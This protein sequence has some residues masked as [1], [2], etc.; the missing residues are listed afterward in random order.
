ML[1]EHARHAVPDWSWAAECVALR[2][3]ML[4]SGLLSTACIGCVGRQLGSCFEKFLSS[5]KHEKHEAAQNE[6][7]AG[8]VAG[9]ASGGS[10]L[11]TAVATV[12]PAAAGTAAYKAPEQFEDDEINTKGEVYSYAIVLRELLHGDQPWAG[13]KDVYISY[14]V[15]NKPPPENRPLMAVADSTLR[16]LVES[17][18]AQAAADRPSFADVVARLAAAL[19]TYASSDFKV[20]N[21]AL[22]DRIRGIP[23]QPGQ[24]LQT[25]EVLAGVQAMVFEYDAHRHGID[26]E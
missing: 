2:N 11:A 6:A 21:D 23:P 25:F 19:R 7:L 15:C 5:V 9:A 4:E 12:M 26:L 22:S 14:R 10:A 20:Q 17:C 1:A 13:R 3:N 16:Q 8:G 24:S 18:W